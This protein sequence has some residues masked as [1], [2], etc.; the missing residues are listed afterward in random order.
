MTTTEPT[1]SPTR[2]ADRYTVL[3]LLGVGG[4][5]SVYRVH[6]EALDEIVALKLL[7]RELVGDP[8]ERARFRQEV[9][10]ARR[11][12]HPNVARVFDLGEA[13]GE[14]F[15]TMEYIEGTTLAT[16]LNREA[17]LPVAEVATLGLAL[18]AGLGAVHEAGIVHR[19]FKPDNVLLGRDGRVALTDFGIA[20]TPPHEGAL[21]QTQGLIM[22]TPDYMAP[23]QV[24][25]A[26]DLDART[27]IY[28]FGIVLFEM[29]TG[30][31][32]FVAS[33][34]L[35][36]AIARL[37]QSAPDPGTVRP[38]LSRG[39]T[40]LIV[41]CLQRKR[42]ERPADIRA[43]ADA[44]EALGTGQTLAMA[45]LTRPLAPTGPTPLPA[46]VEAAHPGE[47]KV[48]VLPFRNLG[49]PEDAYFAD[50]I[51][52]DI[53]DTLAG[54]P[55]LRVRPRATVARAAAGV[56][57]P[58]EVGRGLG[59]DV[60]VEGSVRRQMDTLRI[61]ARLL[62]MANGFAVWAQRFEGSVASAF[63]LSDEVTEGVAAA[64]AVR[65][66]PARTPAR[67][68]QAMELYLRGR[69]A[70]H[71]FWREAAQ[72]AVDLLAE[73]VARSPENTTILSAYAMAL[74]RA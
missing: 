52:D 64:L 8:R 20:R 16:R 71:Q 44:L 47:K 23:E 34:P 37:T 32:P 63:A 60:V 10:L 30:R 69:Q 61:Q 56:E 1:A 62:C 73:A 40:A 19:D 31:R 12:A 6:D 48:A 70:Y 74:A 24:E 68:A 14:V 43:V 58:L 50:G 22:G 17:P 46:P 11:V 33:T 25:D 65:S 2:L 72:T 38:G 15:L 42:A 21:V 18:C 3:S 13:N 49:A 41:A 26:R 39:L 45:P 57:D 28:A 4:M 36:T 35:A 5:G 55:G 59:V 9:K 53:S 54:L 66:H 7:R 67:D 51:A 27:D 29:A